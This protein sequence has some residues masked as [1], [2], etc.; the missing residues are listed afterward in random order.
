MKTLCVNK[1]C[2][3]TVKREKGGELVGRILMTILHDIVYPERRVI[4]SI[5]KFL[6]VHDGQIKK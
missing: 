6:K 5:N 4:A 3:P 2:R 1:R